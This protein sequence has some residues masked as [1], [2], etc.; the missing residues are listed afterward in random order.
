MLAAFASIFLWVGFG[1]GEREFS[2]ST[3]FFLITIINQGNEII[4]RI[5]FGGCGLV[6][7]LV[8]VLAAYGGAHKITSETTD[9]EI[10]NE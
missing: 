10:T 4:G 9:D 6:M 8:T 7:V 3:S 2:S 1:P 5:L